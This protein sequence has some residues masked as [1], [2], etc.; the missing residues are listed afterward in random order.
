MYQ[1]QIMYSDSC[2]LIECIGDTD[3]KNVEHSIEKLYSENK[4]NDV[5]ILWIG[6]WEGGKISDTYDGKCWVRRMLGC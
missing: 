3:K 2:T 1:I 4:E 5:D 6:L